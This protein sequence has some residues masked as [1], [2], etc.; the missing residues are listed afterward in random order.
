MCIAAAVRN[1]PSLLAL[2]PHCS[3][4][5]L[6]WRP[7]WPEFSTTTHRSYITNFNPSPPSTDEKAVQTTWM[8]IQYPC[9]HQPQ[10]FPW[11]IN[12][13]QILLKCIYSEYACG[14]PGIS[15]PCKWQH[16]TFKGVNVHWERYAK[17]WTYL[18]KLP[19]PFRPPI[20]CLRQLLFLAPGRASSQC[21]VW[22][23]HQLHHTRPLPSLLL[24]VRQWPSRWLWKRC[25]P[26]MKFA[27]VH[28]HPLLLPMLKEMN[29][30]QLSSICV[31]FRFW[32][33]RVLRPRMSL[34]INIFSTHGQV[35]HLWHPQPTWKVLVQPFVTPLS[36]P[37]N[38]QN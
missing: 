29:Y 11:A 12:A 14:I 19:L 20:V 17:K 23:H 3:E 18:K 21:T 31:A 6:I 7:G 22:C 1:W 38:P 36:P 28:P 24:P 30:Y 34:I 16:G 35:F 25:Y 27:S 32:H 33:S 10:Y 5:D 9:Q 4:I 15:M 37:P 8:S 2:I 26:A 13:S